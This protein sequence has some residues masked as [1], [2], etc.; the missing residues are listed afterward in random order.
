MTVS[1]NKR[2]QKILAK[3]EMTTRRHIGNLQKKDWEKAL[4]KIGHK[5]KPF[6]IPNPNDIMPKRDL[7]VMKTE[8]RGRLINRNMRENLSDDLRR[9]LRKFRT[10]G[11]PSFVRLR[12]A[13]AGTINP[14]LVKDFEERITSTFKDY[15]KKD[16]RLGVPANVHTMAVTET[17]SVINNAKMEYMYELNN[18][19][20]DLRMKKKWV[21]NKSLSRQPRKNHIRMNNR[22][23]EMH[24]FFKVPRIEGGYDLMEQPHDRNAPPEQVIGCHCD[25]VFIAS[26]K[27]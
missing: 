16:P 24:S 2:L 4:S 15:T 22:K 13:K 25:V 3:N 1:Y 11:Q 26:K 21:H 18:R 5:E 27:S 17:R 9:T 19:N 23:V 10:T 20:P 8:E 12:G 6:Q 7:I 14:K